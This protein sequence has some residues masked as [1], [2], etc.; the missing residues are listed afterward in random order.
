MKVVLKTLQNKKYELDVA[1][2]DTVFNVEACFSLVPFDFH[3]VFENL[4]FATKTTY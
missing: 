3:C 4:D 2:S 1:E